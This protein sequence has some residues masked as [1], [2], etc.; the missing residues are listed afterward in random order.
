MNLQKSILLLSIF[1]L[2]FSLSIIFNKN[3]SINAKSDDL[4]LK[5]ETVTKVKK[6]HYLTGTYHKIELNHK[7]SNYKVAFA[8]NKIK[9][10]FTHLKKGD[11][12]HYF[13]SKNQ[14]AAYIFQIDKK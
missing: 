2:L 7:K 3:N 8:N 12:I 5:I 13:Y 6:T 10:Q 14:N 9:N 4:K 11:K 1:S